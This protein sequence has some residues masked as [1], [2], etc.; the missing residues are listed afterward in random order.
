MIQYI[1]GIITGILLAG[2]SIYFS[3]KSTITNFVK[4][5]ERKIV[6]PKGKVLQP[7]EVVLEET[8]EE[9]LNNK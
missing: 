3:S 9:F 2:M 6:G 5:A 8:L 7:R 1:L 4:E